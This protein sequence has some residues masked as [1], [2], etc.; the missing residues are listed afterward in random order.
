ME[1]GDFCN[2]KARK[3]W[4]N[5]PLRSVKVGFAERSCVPAFVDPKPLFGKPFNITFDDLSHLDR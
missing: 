4:V 1:V 5:R 2:E 3:D